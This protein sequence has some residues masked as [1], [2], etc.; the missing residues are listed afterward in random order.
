VAAI[1][2]AVLVLADRY[3]RLDKKL[4]PRRRHRGRHANHGRHARTDDARSQSTASVEQPT[5][6]LP[7]WASPQSGAMAAWT[8]AL[9]TLMLVMVAVAT[10]EAARQA[11]APVQI[12]MV[13]P[14]SSSSSPVHL[15]LDDVTRDGDQVLLR[16]GEPRSPVLSEQLAQGD[17]DVVRADVPSWPSGQELEDLRAGW[18]LQA[19]TISMLAFIAVAGCWSG[20]SLTRLCVT[21]FAGEGPSG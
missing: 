14:N 19:A 9:L 12:V 11:P 7:I 18:P 20:R 21:L 5:A 17:A 8:I 4:R 15:T 16:L 10:L 6:T 1:V 13:S 2:T 3:A